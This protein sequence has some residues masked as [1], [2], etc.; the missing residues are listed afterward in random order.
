VVAAFG[1][2]EYWGGAGV[3]P[4]FFARF[5][6]LE[7]RHWY[8]IAYGPLRLVV[9]D[10]NVDDLTPDAWRGQIAW[11][12]RTLAEIDRD[13]A[14][15]GVVVLLH[16]PPY[17]NSTVTGDELH[18]QRA[19][20]PA[21]LGAAKT[22]AM[23]SGHVHSYERF[24]RSGKAFVVSGGGGGPR[25]RLASGARPR[26]PGDRYA[27]GPLR[28]FHFLLLAPGAR[29]LEVEVK[30]LRKGGVDLASMDRFSLPW[31][32]GRGASVLPSGAFAEID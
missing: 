11:F 16:H 31:S 17:T 13:P 10:S 8:A 9:L 23:V 28:D 5:P 21:F 30:G 24:E 22:L 29:A 19:F 20:V 32:G 25:A 12:E 2:H 26:H 3:E 27:G 7:W 4:H 18:V 6:H 14:A 1:N 15:R